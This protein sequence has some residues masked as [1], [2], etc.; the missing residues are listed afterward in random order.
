MLQSALMF[1]QAIAFL[2]CC[3]YVRPSCRITGKDIS[4]FLSDGDEKFL[5]EACSSWNDYATQGHTGVI[6]LFQAQD[7]WL[8]RLG[9]SR[10]LDCDISGIQGAAR[11]DVKRSAYYKKCP[12][13]PTLRKEI[14][15]LTYSE[16]RRFL[17]AVQKLK[18]TFV[19]NVSR[20]DIIARLHDPTIAPQAHFSA[21]FLPWHREYILRFE[22]A[23]KEIDCFV[24]LPY[25]DSTLDYA[26]PDGRDSILWTDKYM[27]NGDGPVDSGPF[28]NW[29]IPEEVQNNVPIFSTQFRDIL[30][31]STS[32]SPGFFTPR[33]IDAIFEARRFRELVWPVN[34]LF[35]AVHGRIHNWVGGHM[36]YLLSVAFDPVFWLH[37]AFVDCLWEEWREK[38]QEGDPEI[39]YVT[40]DG[41]L[42]DSPNL[43]DFA[44][45]DAHGLRNDYTEKYYKC[46]PRPTCSV[47]QPT[48]N[49][50]YLFCDP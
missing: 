27:G 22:N 21:A 26:L 10:S 39:D 20:Y 50:R 5:E 16:R 36:R 29:S 40:E 41:E 2:T 13:G 37:H 24:T 31:R 28:S 45:G 17:K 12:K 32:E 19:G 25:W 14:R 8:C 3:K 1:L 44:R 4:K 48:C 42:H 46:A 33:S 15:S 35:E 47:K 9:S 49:S 38:F 6:E 34:I 23:L 18:N 30:F 7:I 11:R 43:A